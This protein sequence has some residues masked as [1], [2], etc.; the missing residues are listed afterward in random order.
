M[1]LKRGLWCK[2]YWQVKY[3][4][5][6]NA[7]LNALFGGVVPFMDEEE[8][9][10]RGRPLKKVLVGGHMLTLE[11]KEIYDHLLEFWNLAQGRSDDLMSDEQFLVY[12]KKSAPLIHKRMIDLAMVSDDLK[13]IRAVATDLADRGFGKA[14]TQINLS[15]SDKDLRGAWKQLEDKTVIDVSNLEVVRAIA[16]DGFTEAVDADD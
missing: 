13:A 2:G 6:I 1:V 14:A 11:E 12:Q 7:A 4:K 5:C 15:V 9:K 10:G 3:N 16:A 8:H